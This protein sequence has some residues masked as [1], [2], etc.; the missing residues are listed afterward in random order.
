MSSR[1]LRPDLSV[2]GLP[3]AIRLSERCVRNVVSTAAARIANQ[4]A[5]SDLSRPRLRSSRAYTS[6]TL[7]HRADFGY[8]WGFWFP[9]RR[10]CRDPRS[11]TCV[12]P[13]RTRDVL[14]SLWISDF[15]S[16]SNSSGAD[17]A[18]VADTQKR[19]EPVVDAGVWKSSHSL[20]LRAFPLPRA[21]NGAKVR[22]SGRYGRRQG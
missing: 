8:L 9:G 5:F 17:I 13:G 6:A 1:R 2:H 3:D 22:S 16:V 15:R 18:G 7:A 11:S 4:G 21:A 14:L 10:S 19:Y 12:R 20:P